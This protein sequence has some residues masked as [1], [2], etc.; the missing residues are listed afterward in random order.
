[1][2]D[3]YLNE[4]DM[5]IRQARDLCRDRGAWSWFYKATVRLLIGTAGS[6]VS[7]CSIYPAVHQDA[8][9]VPQVFVDLLGSNW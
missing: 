4:R 2:N 9:P 6:I 5:I 8:W 3:N 7:A 1:M